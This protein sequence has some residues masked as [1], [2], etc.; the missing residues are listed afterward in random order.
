MIDLRRICIDTS[1]RLARPMRDRPDRLE[2]GSSMRIFVVAAFA[3]LWIAGATGRLAVA[4]PAPDS[5]PQAR[6]D[7]EA[8]KQLDA[9]VAE[10]DK[11][12]GDFLTS[13]FE[14]AGE[15]VFKV[16]ADA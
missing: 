5:P 9:L 3:A 10:F 6:S 4:S 11:A 15:G 16:K 12:F 13:A 1:R 8:R 7:P 2:E 14:S